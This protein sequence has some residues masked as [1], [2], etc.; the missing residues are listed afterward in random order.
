MTKFQTF[1]KEVQ[2]IGDWNLKFILDLGFGNWNFE[3]PRRSED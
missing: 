2:T 3:A 1:E